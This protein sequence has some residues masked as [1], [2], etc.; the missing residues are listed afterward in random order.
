[1]KNNIFNTE[2]LQSIYKDI[3]NPLED[4]IKALILDTA[5]TYRSPD[6]VASEGNVCKYHITNGNKPKKCAF[7]RLIP[8]N[9]ARRLQTSGLGSLALFSTDNDRPL[10]V[11]IPAEPLLSKK[12]VTILSRQPEWLL[13]MPLIVFVAIQDFH[14]N[15]F[16]PLFGPRYGFVYAPSLK[17]LTQRRNYILTLDLSKEPTIQSIY[18]DKGYIQ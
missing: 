1:M 2:H 17:K 5:L 4:R 9:D 3:N 12:V 14:D 6:K 13:T 8:T 10:Y 16:G 15:L 7:G 18:K 11:I